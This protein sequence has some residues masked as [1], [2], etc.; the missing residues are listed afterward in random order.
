MAL[1]NR[2]CEERHVTEFCIDIVLVSSHLQLV[3]GDFDRE[4][5]TSSSGNV[6][7]LGDFSGNVSVLGDEISDLFGHQLPRGLGCS[8]VRS[9]LFHYLQMIRK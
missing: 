6:S 8:E 5:G 3:L 7:V 2:V 9:H 1:L 4:G